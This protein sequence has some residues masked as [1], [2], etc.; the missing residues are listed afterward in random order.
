MGAMM[1]MMIMILLIKMIM[2]VSMT[3]RPKK[4]S[5]FIY[6]LWCTK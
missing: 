1:M 3:M 4:F 2:M 5:T 6:Q